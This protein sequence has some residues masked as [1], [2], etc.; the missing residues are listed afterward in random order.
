[1]PLSLQLLNEY[2][3]KEIQRSC[4][5]RKTVDESIRIRISHDSY[6]TLMEQGILSEPTIRSAR[7]PYLLSS[8]KI[9]K[10][11]NI[12]IAICKKTPPPPKKELSFN[13]S[14]YIHP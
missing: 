14:Q 9:R 12:E 6:R 1:M 5:Q 8:E 11:I 4:H 13:W 10:H 3:N 2:V 7:Q